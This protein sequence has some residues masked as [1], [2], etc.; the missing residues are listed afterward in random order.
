MP[1][2]IYFGALNEDISGQWILKT[3]LK[4]AGRLDIDWER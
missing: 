1:K 3:D 4:H 2:V